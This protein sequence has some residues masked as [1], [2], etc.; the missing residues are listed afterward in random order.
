MVPGRM[1]PEL[2]SQAVGK[3][4]TGSLQPFGQS[5]SYTYW[6]IHSLT[7]AVIHSLIHTFLQ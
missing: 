3:L 2:E 1:E 6:L 5:C 4:L 7:L